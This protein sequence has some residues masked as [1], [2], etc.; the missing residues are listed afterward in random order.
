MPLITPVC[1]S[2]TPRRMHARP[3]PWPLRP[4]A[5]LIFALAFTTSGSA[6]KPATSA[7][8][9]KF[10]TLLKSTGLPIS[11]L[12]DSLAVIPY[13]GQHIQSYQVLVQKIGDL[14]IIHTNLTESLPVKIQENRFKYLLQQNDHFDLIKISLGSDEAAYIRADL[15][16]STISKVLLTRAIRQV[17]NVTNIVAGELMVK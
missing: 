8:P 4:L 2:M 11:M 16:A 5:W 14:Y 7:A 15:Y 9:G 1:A 13:Q 12:N 17:A 3:A 10:Q 6:Q